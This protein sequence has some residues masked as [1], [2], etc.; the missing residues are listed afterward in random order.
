MF[1]PDESKC[2]IL[3]QR[4]LA[5]RAK[6]EGSTFG[7]HLR[8]VSS[9]LL[10]K[11]YSIHDNPP[12]PFVLPLYPLWPIS[13]AGRLVIAASLQF[14]SLTSCTGIEILPSLHDYASL[15]LSS[16]SNPFMS[17]ICGTGVAGVANSHRGRWWA[18][19]QL[20]LVSKYNHL[21]LCSCN[22]LRVVLVFTTH[23]KPPGS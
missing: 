8:G 18:S 3:N 17:L 22:D 7:V 4:L 2:S 12:P 10:R 13:G 16:N 5:L 20:W 9:L 11:G 19:Q 15:I 6:G 21:H 1:D 14:P 23:N